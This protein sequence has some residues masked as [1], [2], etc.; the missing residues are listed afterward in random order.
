MAVTDHG[1][2]LPVVRDLS[3]LDEG[4]RGM[5]LV[6]VLAADWGVRTDHGTS[7]SV[8]FEVDV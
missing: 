7:K 4:G 3:P 5:M 1:A 2:G 6:E 8:W